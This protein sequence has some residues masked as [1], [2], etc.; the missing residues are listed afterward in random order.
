[1]F[2]SLTD[3]NKHNKTITLLFGMSTAGLQVQSQFCLGLVIV[4]LQQTSRA[5]K[6]LPLPAAVQ[7]S[8]VRVCVTAR[9]I[10]SLLEVY[11]V[12]ICIVGTNVSMENTASEVLE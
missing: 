8:N 5:E 7:D 1:M 9:V 12:D 4:T 11:S 3:S 10:V 6:S 2:G